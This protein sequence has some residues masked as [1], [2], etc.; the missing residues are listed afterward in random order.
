M[1]KI[2]K[3]GTRVGKYLFGCW[4]GVQEIKKKSLSLLS[5]FLML[6]CYYN[7][8]N[9][10]ILYTLYI[11]LHYTYYKRDGEIENVGEKRVR[12]DPECAESVRSG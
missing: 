12:A 3:K 9:S 2:R 1:L 8:I 11:C 5:Y 6:I 10:M 7:I 4:Y